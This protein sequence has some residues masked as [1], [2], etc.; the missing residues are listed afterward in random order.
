M[1]RNFTATSLPIAITLG[2]TLTAATAAAQPGAAPAPAPDPEA[3]A[4]S[5]TVDPG[6]IEDVNADRVWL[7]PTGL[8]QPKGSWSFN[9]TELMF[10]GLTYGVTDTTQVSA[11]TWVLVDEE[12]PFLLWLNAKQQL[13][14]QGKLRLALHG[15]WIHVD[16]RGDSEFDEDSFDVVAL[17]GAA[18]LCLDT[19]CHSLVNGY[20]GT[21][22][23]LDEGDEE[24]PVI[25]AVSLVKRINRHVK[26]IGE[27]DT[28]WEFGEEPSNDYLGWYGLRFTSGVVG[29]D[30]G[31]VKPFGDDVD[32]DEFPMGFPMLTF[33]YRAI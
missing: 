20:V 17:G 6:V 26:F 4:V 13:L 15:S 31:F 27:I 21:A 33:T 8:T 12:Q 22:W 1:I 16:D 24:R 30:I 9:D 23:A 10:L 32:T 3:A 14:R 2:L 25:A 7:T 5:T 28:G 19:G 11:T 18:S 29:G